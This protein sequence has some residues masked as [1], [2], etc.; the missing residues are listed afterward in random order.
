ME[1]LITAHSGCDATP[2]NSIEFVK[3]AISEGAKA[4]EVDIRLSGSFLVISHDEPKDDE[5]PPTLK[6]VFTLA[7]ESDILINCDLKSENIEQKVYDL[8]VECGIE[9]QIL[10]SGTVDYDTVK[11]IDVEVFYNIE[12][13]IP[14]IYKGMDSKVAV[15]K[16]A[17]I[18][19]GTKIKTIN[20]H[21]KL[22]TPSFISEAKKQGLLISAWTVNHLED[23]KPLKEAGIRN[24]TTR[25]FRLL[26][27]NL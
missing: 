24:I 7:S 23:A 5:T 8:A 3:Y 11:D 10:Y 1:T 20:C 21:Y 26:N 27:E 15:Q 19:K 4:M 18:A 22:V 25:A 12:G 9:K 16:M 14:E 17:E 6:E 2:D 13:F